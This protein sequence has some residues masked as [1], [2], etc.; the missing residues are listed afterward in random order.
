MNVE[1]LNLGEA[2]RLARERTNRERNRA[3]CRPVDLL[4]PSYGLVAYQGKEAPYLGSF[5]QS[6]LTLLRLNDFYRAIFLKKVSWIG[7]GFLR[8]FLNNLRY[9]QGESFGSF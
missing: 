7:L 4:L 2:L 3:K 6:G 5:G 8:I 9:I 1:N